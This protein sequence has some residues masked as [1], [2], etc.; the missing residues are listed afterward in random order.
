MFSSKPGGGNA[1]RHRM[2]HADT[3][4]MHVDEILDLQ[5][6]MSLPLLFILSQSLQVI[7]VTLRTSQEQLSWK[8]LLMM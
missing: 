8:W 5:Y 6:Y 4:I 7:Y 2:T 1:N 3:I